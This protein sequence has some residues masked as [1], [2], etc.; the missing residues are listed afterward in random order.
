MSEDITSQI[1]AFAAILENC[2]I[3]SFSN[4][5]YKDKGTGE[6]CYWVSVNIRY[7]HKNGGSNGMD[8]V[9]ADYRSSGWEFSDAGQRR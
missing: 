1:G 6:L 5:V 3:H 4:G 7:E 8:M 2:Y 9:R